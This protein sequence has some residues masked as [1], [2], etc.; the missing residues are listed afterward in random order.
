MPLVLRRTRDNLIWDNSADQ[1]PG[2][3]IDDI[4]ADPITDLNTRENELSI[5]LIQDE[6]TELDRCLSAL[7][8]ERMNLQDLDYILFDKDIIDQLLLEIN[9][10]EGNL[11]DHEINK[12]HRN[13]IKLSAKKLIS[14]SKKIME[15]CQRKRILEEDVARIIVKS[16]NNNWI[17]KNS[18][19]KS[20]L[21]EIESKYY[22]SEIR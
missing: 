1:L 11:K 4:A 3:E 15:K 17:K 19:S 12:L 13:I 22:P 8:A 9:N 14:L 16:I 21:S 5:Y 20:L 2:L 10:V 7:A 6:L 18:L